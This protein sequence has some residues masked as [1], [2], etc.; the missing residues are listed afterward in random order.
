MGQFNINITAVGGHGCER[1]AKAG[2]RLYGRCQRLSCPD[3]LAYDF[4][5]T[6]RAKGFNVESA[7]FTHWPNTPTQVVDDLLKNVRASGQF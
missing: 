7:T 4:V 3:C 5:Q 2:D 1:N 6:M